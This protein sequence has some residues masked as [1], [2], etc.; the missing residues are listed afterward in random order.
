MRSNPHEGRFFSWKNQ[1]KIHI[2]GRDVHSP[3]AS[4]RLASTSCLQVGYMCILK[5]M[6]INANPAMFTFRVHYGLLNRGSSALRESLCKNQA[7]I[8]AK[9][10]DFPE[11]LKIKR[12][13]LCKVSDMG[14]TIFCALL[15]V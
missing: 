9:K 2:Y 15:F 11:T 7:V 1:D 8:W 4:V 6:C 10:I 3:K 14:I 5:W 13:I 12:V